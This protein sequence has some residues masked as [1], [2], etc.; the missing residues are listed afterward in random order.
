M[1]RSSNKQSGESSQ[2]KWERFAE[3]EGVKPGMKE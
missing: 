1:L 2:E 3:K